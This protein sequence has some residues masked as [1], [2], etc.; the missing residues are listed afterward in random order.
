MARTARN[1]QTAGSLN[2][3]ALTFTAVDNTN[4][5]SFGYGGGRNR[6]LVKN[7][8]GSS[9]TVTMHSNSVIDG[10]TLAD[11][12]A[13]TVAAGAIVAIGEA[14]TELQADGNV[15]VDYSSGTTITACLIQV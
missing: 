11:R 4:G 7:G 1:P 15:Y 6:L 2:G 12:P 13:I 5:E 10:I 8:S 3:T 9:M 14:V